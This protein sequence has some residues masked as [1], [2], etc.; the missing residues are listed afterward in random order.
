VSKDFRYAGSNDPNEIA[1]YRK[2]SG[3]KPHPVGSLKPNELGIYD[4]SGNIWE[5]CSDYKIPYPCDPVRRSF[6][7]RVL[8]GGT[9]TSDANSV[10][11]RDRN[12][13]NADLRLHTIGF[14]LAEDL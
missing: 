14:R 12:G 2:N 1:W 11:V 4:M 10:R 5:W 13:R 3:A 9:F 7:A 8:R 6:D